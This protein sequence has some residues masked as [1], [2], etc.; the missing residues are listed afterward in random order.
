MMAVP[1]KPESILVSNI[2]LIGDVVLTTALVGLLKHAY[3][4]ARIDVLVNRGTGEFLEK[5]QRI[6]RVI[7][8]EK[9]QR[10]T[11][12]RG[13]AYLL[14]LLRSYDIAICMNSADRGT[15]ATVL[16]GR[17]VRVGFFEPEKPFGAF[18]RKAFLSHPLQYSLDEH[19]MFRCRQVAKALGIPADTLAVKIFWDAADR[20]LVQ[21][22][23]TA[24]GIT[25]DYV[26]LHPFA[27]WRYK[28]W[29][30]RRFAEVSDHIVRNF[31]LR[32]VW[33]SS[34]DAEERRQLF[35]AADACACTPHLIAGTFSL[36][37]MAC[38][39]QGARLYVGLDTAI[40][41]I[42][43]STGI[44][45]LALYGPTELWRWHPWDNQSSVDHAV[46]FGYRGVFRSGNVVVVQ[47]PCA[48]YP[49]IRPQCY[50]GGTENPCLMALSAAR[51]CE[52]IDQLMKN[53]ARQ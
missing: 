36:N 40:T 45:T 39:L 38:L 34:P 25:T 49:C 51:V 23:L 20:Q 27:R 53:T 24:A 33:T 42:A 16:A 28:Y 26:V 8:S 4:A 37:Q 13:N 7:F 47:E 14:K 31:G 30:T 41:H 32:P 22:T 5:D 44:P 2:R 18:L 3:P 6:N 17:Q 29:D 9:W 50:Q 52:E 19:P 43:A 15:L 10:G 12:W 46:P 48:H 11:T 21:D 1:E 35:E